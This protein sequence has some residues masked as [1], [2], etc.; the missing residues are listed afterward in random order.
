MIPG[1]WKLEFLAMA[2]HAWP[3]KTNLPK[4]NGPGPTQGSEEE[5]E[6]LTAKQ[7]SV[8][9]WTPPLTGKDNGQTCIIGKESH[10]DHETG[11]DSEQ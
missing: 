8:H 3:S 1:G 6:A 4:T 10:L 2:T 5:K 9:R 11:W 7:P